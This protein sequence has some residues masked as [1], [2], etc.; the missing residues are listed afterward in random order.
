MSPQLHKRL[1]EDIVITIIKQYISKE[2]SCKEAMIYLGVKRARFFQIISEY[3]NNPKSFSIAYSRTTP[4]HFISNHAEELI[5]QELEKDKQLIEN[6][7]IAIRT[8]NYSAMRDA[9]QE[10]HDTEI[11]VT[12]IIS[13]AKQLG[14]YKQKKEKKIHDREV[15]TNFVGE[16]AQHDSSHHLWS[17]YME[18]SCI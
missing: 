2:I 10:K 8:Y 16:L 4:N 12:T 17:P 18:E 13:R 14:Y 11:S 6:K 5:L 9:L 1:D 7:D 15:L 3:R